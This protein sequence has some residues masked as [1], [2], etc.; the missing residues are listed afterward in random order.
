MSPR[1]EVM[2]AFSKVPYPGDDAL[3]CCGC[4]ECRWE[5][6]QLRGK[7]WT[8]L[9]LDDFAAANFGL[10]TPAAFHYFLPGLILLALD[11]PALLGEIVGTVVRRLT[12]SDREGDGARAQVDHGIK[13]LS[14]RQRRVVIDV[15]R[16]AEGRA[17]HV[18]AIWQSALMNLIDGAATPY[19]QTAVERWLR[20]QTG[21]GSGQPQPPS[22]REP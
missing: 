9:S 22:G 11:H 21:G 8:R 13:R 15:I 19:S 2:F 1:D 7:K 20:E 17:P 12:V 18:P 14:S 3:A 6:A 10:L 4:D 16:Q 5:V